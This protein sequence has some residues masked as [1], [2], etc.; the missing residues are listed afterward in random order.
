[1]DVVVPISPGEWFDK[2]TILQLKVDRL[3][4]DDKR[5]QA[6]KHLYV[7][8]NQQDLRKVDWTACEEQICYLYDI[9]A[10]L[11]DFEEQIRK[12][13]TCNTVIVE[14]S[15]QIRHWNAERASC[16]RIIDETFESRLTEVKDYG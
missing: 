11:W 12:P 16:K 5:L 3:E 15:A 4:V 13:D 1:M 6:W 9:N 7:L 2:V 8:M 10:K 14:L